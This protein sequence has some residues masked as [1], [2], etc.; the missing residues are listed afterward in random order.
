MVGVTIPSS[1]SGSG[2]ALVISHAGGSVALGSFTLLSEASP[3]SVT[4][5]VIT[6]NDVIAGTP[7]TMTVSLNPTPTNFSTAG[8]LLVT[9][10]PTLA[11]AIPALAPVPITAN[12]MI[13]TIPTSIVQTS[14]SGNL[15]VRHNVPNAGTTGT[16]AITVRPPR[17]TAVAVAGDTIAGSASASGS[18]SFDLPGPATVLL[19][20][21]NPSVLAVPSSVVRS[22]NTASFSITTQQ[23]SQPQSVTIT[24]SLN[25]V[26]ATKTV[27]VRPG[28]LTTLT[29][30]PTAVNGGEGGQ[31]TLSFDVPVS[32]ASVT[33]ASSDTALGVASSTIVNGTSRQVS[34][35]TSKSLVAPV[36]A[37]VTATGGVAK[38][39][40][41]QITPIQLSQFT[42]SPASGTGGATLPATLRLSRTVLLTQQLV[43]LRS[44]DTTV[45]TVPSGVLL[46]QGED[47]KVITVT[48][49]GPQAAS[50]SATITAELVVGTNTISSP[51][52]NSKSIT[53]TANP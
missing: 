44:S 48:L 20:S 43:K 15:S 13:V 24:A 21:S 19:S 16:A 38:T 27:V 35:S 49:R 25:A 23:V 52:I 6:P 50:R 10:P 26:T 33:L 22:G 9:I 31:L 34:F 28:R 5:V 7:A 2:G 17:P 3:L 45:A 18:V 40:T 46:S 53:V 42:V 30:A 47:V 11:P 14:F 41:V 37:T 12:P 39:A 51:V 29:A 4:G 32:N 36:T 1:L 8:S